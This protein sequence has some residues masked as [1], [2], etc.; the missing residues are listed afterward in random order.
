MGEG[1]NRPLIFIECMALEDTTDH[2]LWLGEKGI[3]NDKASTVKEILKEIDRVTPND[4]RRVARKIFKPQRLN[5][6]AIG[7][8][9]AK[10]RAK[11][12]KTMGSI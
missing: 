9:V 6:A 10:E 4:I 2:M 3:S 11:I 12:I 1:A 5:I 7:P 8:K